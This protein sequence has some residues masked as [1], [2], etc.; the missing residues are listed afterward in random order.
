VY[1]FAAL[2]E[3]PELVVAGGAF[4]GIAFGPRGELAVASNDTAYRFE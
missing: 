2:D 3:P 1:R 4:V